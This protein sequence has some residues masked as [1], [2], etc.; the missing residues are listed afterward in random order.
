MAK[1]HPHF[2]AGKSAITRYQHIH[3]SWNSQKV[4][5]FEV[6]KASVTVGLYRVGK[7]CYLISGCVKI[8][9][10]KFDVVQ[11]DNYTHN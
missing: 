7:S 8:A 11:G 1:L 3:C 4:A 9:L 6:S 5:Y 2:T 10:M